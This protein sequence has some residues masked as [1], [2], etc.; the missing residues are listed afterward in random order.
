MNHHSPEGHC[1]I[2]FDVR[3][4][5]RNLLGEEG[6]GFTIA[7]ARLGPGRIHHCMRTIGQCE[8]ALGM[9]VA[10]AKSRIAFGS[11]LAE[12]SNIQDWI[13][14]SRIEIDQA[15]LLVLRAAWLMDKAG[16]KA[17]RVDVSAI[18][19][20]AG[21]LQRAFLTARFRCSARPASPGIPRSL[22]SGPGDAR[23]VSSTAPTKSICELSPAPS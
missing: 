10:R 18:K 19:V 11:A 12:Y 1:E 7:Q 2:D 13:A 4:P 6:D 16:N 15:R 20:V 14:Q 22:T 8:L 3:V 9:M 5:A 23:S 21:R 17:A